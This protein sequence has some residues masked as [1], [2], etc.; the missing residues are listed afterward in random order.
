M[1]TP[2][3]EVGFRNCAPFTKRITKNN[4]TTTDNAEDLDLVMLM[5]NLN[6]QYRIYNTVLI[7]LT[8]QVFYGFIQKMKKL[9]VLLMLLKV[10]TLNLSSIKLNH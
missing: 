8:Q 1:A 9:I 10:I 2:A 5:Y 3:T 7:I 4:I 6:T